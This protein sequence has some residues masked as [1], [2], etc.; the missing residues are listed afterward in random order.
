MIKVKRR[1]VEG[2]KTEQEGREKV[3]RICDPKIQKASNSESG[4]Q[5]K[6]KVKFDTFAFSPTV[7]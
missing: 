1:D 2:L 5:Q 7:I 4:Q 3:Q 6:K